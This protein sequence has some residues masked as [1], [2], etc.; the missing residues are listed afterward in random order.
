VDVFDA[1]ARIG[2]IGRLEDADNLRLDD[3]AGQLYAG[4]GEALAV[5]DVKQVAVVDRREGKV[6]ASWPIVGAERNFPM[7]LDAASHRLF[8]ATRSPPLVLA[9]DTGSGRR[10]AS[11][12]TCGDA[13]DLFFDGKRRQLYVVCGEGKVEVV[14][15]LSAGRYGVAASL[16]TSPG[17]R[18]GLFVPRLDALFVAAPAATKSQAEVLVFGIE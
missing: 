5:I 1:R 11:I 9:Y 7:A 3:A 13:D 6:V 2:R 10:L 18:T 8:V 17:A 4:Y 12:R 15:E 14:R 16:A